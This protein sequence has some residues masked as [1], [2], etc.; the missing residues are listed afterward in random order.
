MVA[1]QEFASGEEPLAWLIGFANIGRSPGQ[2]C[3]PRGRA[4][5]IPALKVRDP[6]DQLVPY[7]FDELGE[8]PEIEEDALDK[9]LGQQRR[10][11]RQGRFWKYWARFKGD[12]Q[13]RARPPQSAPFTPEA[14]QAFRAAFPPRVALLLASRV[15]PCAA[16]VLSEAQ[17]KILQSTRDLLRFAFLEPMWILHT[18]VGRKGEQVGDFDRRA[19]TDLCQQFVRC[20]LLYC[21]RSTDATLERVPPL[22]PRDAVTT[23]DEREVLAQQALW[24]EGLVWRYRAPVH[25]EVLPGGALRW[26]AI[27]FPALAWAEALNACFDWPRFD[28]RVSRSAAWKALHCCDCCGAFFLQTPGGRGRPA[29]YCGLTCAKRAGER[30]V[31]ERRKRTRIRGTP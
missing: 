30:P 13:W 19:E 29:G 14:W 17:L 15:I 6:D 25:L 10:R 16:E 8:R 18:L 12:T 21:A 5:H 7:G 9:L 27:G 2:I 1:E 4:V 31:G 11:Q 3:P 24:V 28:P 23:E 22:V 26:D 20:L